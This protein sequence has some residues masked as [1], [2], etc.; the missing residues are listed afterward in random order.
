M[1]NAVNIGKFNN[2]VGQQPQGPTCET[3]WWLAATQ[4]NQMGFEVSVGLFNIG[5]ITFS[6]IKSNIKTFL[7]KSLLEKLT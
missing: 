5:T 4:G 6:S 1:R 3:F 7:N 2:L